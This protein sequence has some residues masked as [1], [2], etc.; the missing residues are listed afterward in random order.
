VQLRASPVGRKSSILLDAAYRKT[1]ELIISPPA[2]FR[3]LSDAWRFT[4]IDDDALKI[5]S[6]RYNGRY[7]G[8]GDPQR[9][10]STRIRADC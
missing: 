9:R 5:L 2:S 4:T 6:V 8:I 10:S 1:F 3:G 7:N